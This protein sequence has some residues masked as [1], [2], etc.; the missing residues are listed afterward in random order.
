M[1]YCVPESFRWWSPCHRVLDAPA[2]RAHT[3]AG[4]SL[5]ELLI[6]VSLI[7]IMAALALPSLQPNI[8]DQ[9]VSGA[10]VMAAD[11]D[12]ARS[13]AIANDSEYRITFDSAAN[14]YV[15]THVG[16]N[17]AL[18]T[19]PDPLFPSPDD[20]STQQVTSFDDFPN[21]RAGNVRLLGAVSAGGTWMVLTDVTFGPLGETAL[22]ED[23]IIWLT[24][25]TGDSR[26][27]ISLQVNHTT[28]LTTVGD[29]TGALPAG[30]PLFVQRSFGA[31][32]YVVW[33]RTTQ[34][35]RPL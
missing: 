27:F 14:R 22:P 28:G 32:R 12:Y 33:R 34:P 19:L 30:L 25:G 9:L 18:N 6:V 3:I 2:L 10:Y 13:L 5:L 21:L 23:T 35:A 16:A 11:L 26:R 17:P 4:F 8:G 24:A 20:T 29:L 31:G 7:G 15:L 1:R